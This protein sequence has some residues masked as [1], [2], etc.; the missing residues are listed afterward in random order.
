MKI[1][2]NVT[3]SVDHIIRVEGASEG[4]LAALKAE[5]AALRSKVDSQL[6]TADDLA[7]LDRQNQRINQIDPVPGGPGTGPAPTP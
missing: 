6:P 7:N 2:I 3:G 5:V 4:D 1:D